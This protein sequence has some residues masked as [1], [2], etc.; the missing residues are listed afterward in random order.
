MYLLLFKAAELW[1][2]IWIS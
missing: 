2:F 1:I